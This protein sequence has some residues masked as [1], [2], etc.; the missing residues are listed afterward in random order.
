MTKDLKIHEGIPEPER[1]EAIR[2]YAELVDSLGGEIIKADS[3]ISAIKHK[4]RQR[5][6]GF[7]LLAL[8]NETLLTDTESS[9]VL[10]KTLYLI[11]TT[12]CMDS[13]IYLQK[14][15]KGYRLIQALG[16][17]SECHTALLNQTLAFEIPFDEQ[18][19]ALVVNRSTALTPRLEELRETFK[20]PYLV[21]VPV[22]DAEREGLL[23]TGRL[24]EVKPFFPPLDQGD[25][26]TMRAIAGTLS[27][28]FAN[29]RLYDGLASLARSLARFVPEE[30]LRFL[31]KSSILEV[32]A[33]DHTTATMH[34]M[35]ADIR[36]FTTLSESMTPEECFSF[37]N[38]YLR[39]LE[40]VIRQNGGYIDK[41]MGDGIMALFPGKADGACQAAIAMLEQVALYNVKRE[42][43]GHIPIRIGIGIHTGPLVLGIVGGENRLEG[44]VISDAVNA[45]SRIETLTKTYAS[46]LL[47]S[48]DVLAALENKDDYKFRSIDHVK[49]KG[50][51]RPLSIVEILNHP[52]ER[53]AEKKMATRD[54]FEQGMQTFHDGWPLEALN[55]FKQVLEKNPADSVARHYLARCLEHHT[56]VDI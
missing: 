50:K 22:V 49:V 12:L 55:L 42:Q 40:P 4:I 18:D 17:S 32:R 10:R 6:Q 16:L 19:H 51:T 35:F 23:I 3:T 41:Y 34:V 36:S 2:Y 21:A 30:V 13:A 7:R 24:K 1:V 48:H 37:V 33:G 14:E 54:I 27:Q 53:D 46:P 26:Q 56:D 52:F 45:A 5:E 15:S 11:T 44:T 39:R 9:E 28:A 20:L 47:I 38:A 29:Y 25:A 43:D 8:L 31:N